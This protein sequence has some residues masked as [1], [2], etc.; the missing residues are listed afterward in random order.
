[1]PGSFGTALRLRRSDRVLVTLTNRRTV[2]F[3][4]SEAR[5]AAKEQLDAHG[6]VKLPSFLDPLLLSAILKAIE[7]TRFHVRIHDGIGV[8]LCAEPGAASGV[9]E[10][11]MNDPALF[12]V[13]SDLAGCGPIGCFEGRVYR[14]APS[15]DHYDS[16][17]S[18]VG[19]DRLLAL[20]INL[21]REPFDGGVLQIRRADSPTV[22]AEVENRTPG[23]AVLFRIDPSLRHR[24]N[25]VT[26]TTARMAYAGWFRARPSYRELLHAR[27]RS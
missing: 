15:T 5:R 8:E 3:A 21:G 13:V 23:D 12:D 25:A 4:S 16:W 10:F 24:V 14:L 1:L 27:L 2:V 17:H 6:F 26:G 20:S 19:Q 9:L 7:T 11:L 18:D 22:L